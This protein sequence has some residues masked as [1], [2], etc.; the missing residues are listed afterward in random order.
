MGSFTIDAEAEKRYLLNE[1]KQNARPGAQEYMSKVIPMG[2]KIYGLTVG[3]IREIVRAWQREHGDVAREDLFAVVEAMWDGESREERLV[4]LELLQRYRHWLHDLTWAHFERWRRALDNWELTD[5]LGVGLLGPWVL[6]DFDGRVQHLWHLL[7][8]DDLWSRRLALV[9]SVGLNRCSKEPTLVALTLDLID[10]VKEERHP[11]ITKAVSWALRALLKNHPD[12][13][14]AYL[15]ANRSM[16]ATDV[17]R[18]V[19]NK[20]RTGRKDGKVKK[21][22]GIDK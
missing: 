22:E 21:P 7:A 19:S 5:V 8:D 14:V 20:L 9:S 6:G 10:Q 12:H 11:T 13:V 18:E 2:L 1:I 17:V 4:A 3:T 15:E 16:L